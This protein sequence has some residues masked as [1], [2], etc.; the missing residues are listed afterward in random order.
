MGH[1]GQT[2]PTAQTIVSNANVRN[3]ETQIEEIKKRISK[4]DSEIISIVKQ[5]RDYWKLLYKTMLH[6]KKGKADPV[7]IKTVLDYINSSEPVMVFFPIN[8]VPFK[9]LL[10]PF[11]SKK[12]LA[13]STEYESQYTARLNE[14]TTLN[15]TLAEIKDKIIIENQKVESERIKIEKELAKANA[16]KMNKGLIAG[17]AALGVAAYLYTQD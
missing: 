15:A 7:G 1:F 6:W 12:T 2:P 5:H 10:T 3:L 4:I 14:K 11:K 13:K 9:N 16:P 17:V 8:S